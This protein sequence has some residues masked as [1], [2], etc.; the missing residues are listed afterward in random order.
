MIPMVNLSEAKIFP[1]L[2]CFIYFKTWLVTKPEMVE[3]EIVILFD[4]LFA[5]LFILLQDR[6]ASFSFFSC[7]SCFDY[8]N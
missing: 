3:L 2:M 6:F 1:L 7:F 8:F 4:C 5:V